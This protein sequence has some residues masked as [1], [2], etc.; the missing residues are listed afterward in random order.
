MYKKFSLNDLATIQNNFIPH[1]YKIIQNE[2]CEGVN[3]FFKFAFKEGS[4]LY[5][6]ERNMI[7]FIISLEEKMIHLID[8]I[9][10]IEVEIPMDQKG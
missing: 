3:Q 1:L 2:R 4:K 9:E 10:K 7:S 8:E 6:F 5:Y